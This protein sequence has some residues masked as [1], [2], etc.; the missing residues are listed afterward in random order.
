MYWIISASYRKVTRDSLAKDVRSSPEPDT[1]QPHSC[2]HLTIKRYVFSYRN[3]MR[4]D[5]IHAIRSLPERCT[6]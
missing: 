2:Q 5:L 3:D 1:R 6:R 4:E